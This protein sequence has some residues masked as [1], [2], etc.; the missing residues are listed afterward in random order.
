MRRATVTAA[1]L[2]SLALPVTA[3][4]FSGATVRGSSV[5][6]SYGAQFL[7]VRVVCPPR[8]QSTPRPGD[9]SFCTGT[10]NFFVG[11][12]LVASGP[13]A[14]RT[15]DSHIERMTV[16]RGARSLFRPGRRPRVRWV[17]RS[18]DGRGQ[19]ATRRG[20]VTV[21]NPFKR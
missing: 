12:R 3:S 13:F 5:S 10:G 8:T 21:Y 18:H 19:R 17:L 16:R 20:S 11:R 9:F 14:V 2:G 7:L 6:A 4:A 1:L 15:F